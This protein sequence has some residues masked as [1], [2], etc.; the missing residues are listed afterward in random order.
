MGEKLGFACKWNVPTSILCTCLKSHMYEQK[1]F[2]KTVSYYYKI[3]YSTFGVC[4]VL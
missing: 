2:L 3:I 4:K 1:E